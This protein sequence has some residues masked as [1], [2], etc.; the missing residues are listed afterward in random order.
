M[1][2][3]RL[4]HIA[5]AVKDLD[6]A[7][8]WYTSSLGFSEIERRHTAGKSTSM[9]SAV[10]KAGD[11]VIVLVAGNQEESQVNRFIR[12][13]GEGVQHIALSVD[14]ISA[15]IEV[16]ETNGAAS[17]T[18][19]MSDVGIK[20]TFL[21]RDEGSGVRIELIQRNGGQFSDNSVSRLFSEMERLNIY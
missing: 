15:S 16:A 12:E 4:D 2:I 7:V 19:V 13:F 11:A 17:D 14:D 6:K 1:G 21:R 10:L 5:I 18:G 20:Q 9:D 8:Q 3:M